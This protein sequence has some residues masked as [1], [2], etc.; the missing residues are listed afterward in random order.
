[1]NGHS[2]VAETRINRI[3]EVL[4]NQQLME[5]APSA[6]ASEAH[7]SRSERY[8][9]VP[10]VAVING[11]RDAGFLPV[12]AEQSSTRQLDKQ[13]YTKHMIRFRPVDFLNIAVGDTFPEAVLINAHDGSSRYKL[14]FG[15]F[16]LACSN[17][18]VVADGFVD[19][20]NIMHSGSIIDE[21]IS[22]TKRLLQ[23]AP[24]VLDVVGKWK[25]IQLRP[26]E[27]L[28]L[29]E[30]AHSIRF[31]QTEEDV[32]RQRTFHGPIAPAMLLTTR[33]PEDINPDLWST[34]N[35]IQ[36]NATKG[37]R[38]RVHG[39]RVTARIVGSIDG[40]VKLNK[41]LW[42]LSEKMASIKLAA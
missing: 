3:P 42:T 8:A 31:P 13:N 14:S 1:M 40:D 9:F 28:L 17:G 24:K 10:T 33:R 29:A 36:E 4:S 38:T 25:N 34:F 35:V 12:R 5:R 18:L 39:R 11:M 21:V 32:E 27:Q 22:G 41:A 16:R 37:F 6:F 19:A 15:M 7:S 30:A 2:F 23:Q 26:Q 20:I